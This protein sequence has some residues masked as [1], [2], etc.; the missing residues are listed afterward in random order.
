MLLQ[1]AKDNKFGQVD[2]D[3]RYILAAYPES[4]IHCKQLQ[5][6]PTK[7]FTDLEFGPY[8]DEAIPLSRPNRTR[9]R[10]LYLDAPH[11]H[12]NNNHDWY[13]VG[14]SDT[15]LLGGNWALSTE[16]DLSFS[17]PFG[18]FRFIEPVKE[19][20][21]FP[22]PNRYL[23]GNQSDTPMLEW[24]FDNDRVEKDFARTFQDIETN[25]H[26]AS[27]VPWVDKDK[28]NV[29][30]LFSI[31]NIHFDEESGSSLPLSC[32]S[33]YHN[34]ECGVQILEDKEE[35]SLDSN[36]I[37]LTLSWSGNYSG[38]PKDWYNGTGFHHQEDWFMSKFVGRGHH[39]SQTEDHLSS[40]LVIDLGCKYFPISGFPQEHH[41]SPYRAL[42]YP[43]NQRL[44]SCRDDSNHEERHAH[45]GEESESDVS[46]HEWSSSCFQI[47]LDRDEAFPLILDT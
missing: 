29:G 41:S 33:S 35:V 8:L 12:D 2:T 31:S 46:I 11:N 24:E 18:R 16:R 17:F 44:E 47:S 40:R 34:H 5:W 3:D 39:N 36:R 14:Q 38:P 13:S 19:L 15:E 21:Y 20:N 6:M 37:P 45:F 30:E 26:L 9:G 43:G 25:A 32:V 4:D 1:N 42:E 7:Q 23:V 27:L 22:P 10:I 28:L